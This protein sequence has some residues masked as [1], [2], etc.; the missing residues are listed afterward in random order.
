MKTRIARRLFK[1]SCKEVDKALEECVNQEQLVT[2]AFLDLEH[3]RIT[4][5]VSNRLPPGSSRALK[6][7]L[8]SALARATPHA[9][10]WPVYVRPP[11]VYPFTVHTVGMLVRPQ[12][13]LGQIL[14][15]DIRKSTLDSLQ[16]AYERAA[17]LANAHD[18]VVVFASGGIPLAV[19]LSRDGRGASLEQ[20]RAKFHLL[21]GL[22]WGD[23]RGP[24][25]YFKD[26]IEDNLDQ[27][28]LVIDTGTSGNGVREARRCI[29][30]ALARASPNGR[31]TITIFGIVDGHNDE[32]KN[33]IATV[34]C[35][36]GRTVALRLT[37]HHVAQVLAEDCQH[38]LGYDPNRVE[39]HLTPFRALG[40]FRIVGE[41]PQL[42]LAWARLVGSTCLRRSTWL[43]AATLNLLSRSTPQHL[44]ASFPAT[45]GL[46]SLVEATERHLPQRR[47]WPQLA[48]V[49]T[50]WLAL[51]FAE[52]IERQKFENA[53]QM[54]L[55]DED[56]HEALVKG[57]ERAFRVAKELYPS[58]FWHWADKEVMPVLN[59]E[60]TVLWVDDPA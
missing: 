58:V 1:E 51:G 22:N 12:E 15:F 33:E 43:R 17:E 41:V 18:R 44:M 26:W 52:D 31:G 3:G 9:S 53:M 29:G 45:G 14:L 11:H 19:H 6:S 28:I 7:R 40:L 36:N 10:G 49:A 37:Y 27:S 57:T 5:I 21:P 42:V 23:G 59:P 13:L 34:S 4:A 55:I 16:R 35:A 32:Q 24:Q 48:H 30:E 2:Q 46:R 60:H 39:M 56:A 47:L 38:L 20:Q 54:G 8:R 50:L 25:A